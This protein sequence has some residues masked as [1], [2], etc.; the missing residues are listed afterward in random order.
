MG[1]YSNATAISPRWEEYSFGAGADNVTFYTVPAGRWAEVYLSGNI[2][3]GASQMFIYA[4][5]P[6]GV[7]IVTVYASTGGGVQDNFKLYLPSTAARQIVK[8]P[9]GAFLFFDRNG[10]FAAGSLKYFVIEHFTVSI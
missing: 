6:N 9:P 1:T 4:R 2:T 5:D 3:T 7:D 8:L 10:G